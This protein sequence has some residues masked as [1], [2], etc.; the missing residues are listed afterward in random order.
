MIVETTSMG[1][2]VV[3]VVMASF[4]IVAGAAFI[5]GGIALIYQAVFGK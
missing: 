1:A 3:I 5:W 2:R 4:F